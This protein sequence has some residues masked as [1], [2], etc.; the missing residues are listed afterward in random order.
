MGMVAVAVTA[1][2]LASTAIPPGCER[3]FDGTSYTTLTPTDLVGSAAG[4]TISVWVNLDGP[5]GALSLIHI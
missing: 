2:A 4:F 5:L 1:L 3:H